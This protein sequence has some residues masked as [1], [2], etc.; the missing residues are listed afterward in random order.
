VVSK[1]YRLRLPI[2]QN[3]LETSPYLIVHMVHWVQPPD[4]PFPLPAPNIQHQA[5]C[6]PGANINAPNNINIFQDTI[7]L[8]KPFPIS[9]VNRTA[10]AMMASI[11]GT[12]VLPLSDGS[13]C[14]IPMYDFPY[15]T[16]SNN[17]GRWYNGY[18]LIN[19]LGWC[20]ILL[21]HT[22]YNDASF[23]AL[24]KSNDL[25]FIAGSAPLSSGPR[26]SHLATKPQL[27]S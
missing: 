15:F 8:E 17:S 14:D 4:R 22:R 6:D 10:P 20:R 2:R 3:I 18:C 25:Y 19:M 1:N 11:R 16:S 7:D 26:V 9:S 12:C 21:S 24:N 27:L 13:T 23:I 5:Q